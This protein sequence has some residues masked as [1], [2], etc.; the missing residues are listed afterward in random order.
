MTGLSGSGKTTLA[1]FVSQRLRDKGFQVEVIDGDEYRIN[2]CNDLGFSKKDR[3]T[4][5]RRLGFVGQVLARNFVIAIMSAINP[6]DEIR[7]ELSS[8]GAKLVYIKCSIPTLKARDPKGLYRRAFLPSDHPDH[9]SNFTGVSDPF[10]EP[11]N[12]DLVIDTD[13]LTVEQS[14]DMLEEFILKN[15]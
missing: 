7:K 5:V 11:T 8:K 12:P 6:Y 15:V 2:L 3:N 14:I 10:E 4:N 9:I 13:T 1:R